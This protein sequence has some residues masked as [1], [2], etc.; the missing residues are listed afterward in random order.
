MPDCR[1]VPG[2]HYR[3]FDVWGNKLLD[4]RDIIAV[5]DLCL[6]NG[7]PKFVQPLE[8]ALLGSHSSSSSGEEEAAPQ[9][10]ASAAELLV[11]PVGSPASLVPP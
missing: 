11:G 5:C 4:E 8:E 10:L 6:P 2:V 1:L 3:D 7:R 9:A